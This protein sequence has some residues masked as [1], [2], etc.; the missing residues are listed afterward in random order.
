MRQKRCSLMRR[1]F[2]VELA[3]F[4]MVNSIFAQTPLPPEI[5]YDIV[6]VRAP[7]FGDDVITKMPEIKDPI[8]MEAGTDL[9]L[10]HVDGSEEVLV[11]GGNGAVADP[12]VSFDGKW[13]FYAKVHDLTNTNSQRKK[14]ARSGAD[15]FKINLDTRET[16]QLTF[17]EWTPNTGVGIWSTDHLTANPSGTNYLGYGIYNLGPAPLPNGKLIFTSSRNGFLPNKGFTFPNLQLFVM[18]QDGSNVEFV[19]HLNLGSALHPTVLMDGRVMFSSYEAQG[20]RDRRLW[21]LWSIYPDGRNWGPLM[22]AMKAPS[23]FH[24]QTQLSDGSIVV[25][26][27]YNQN[28]N[29]F[30]MLLKF[31]VSVPQSTAA[32]GSPNPNDSSS[33]S[34]QTGWFSNGKNQYRRYPF[35]PYGIESL[36]PFTHPNDNAAPFLN[37]TGSERTGKVTQPSGAP[38]NDLLLVWSPGPAN[39]LRRPVNR[40]SYDAGLYLLNGGIPVFDHHDLT[41]IKNDPNY[42]EQQPRAVLPYQAIYGI[43]EPQ[44]LPWLPNDGTVRQE[45]PKGTPYGL[46]GTSSFYKRDTKPG[47]GKAEFDGLDPFNTYQNGASSNWGSQGADAG[48]YDNSEIYAVRILGMEP[49]AHLSYGPNSLIGSESTS[50]WRNHASERLRILGEIPLR[51]YDSQGNPVLDPE[52]NPDTSFLAKIPAD[53]PFTFQTIDKDGRLLNAAQT[54]HQVRPG[55]VRY[56]CGGCHAHSQQP[57]DFNQTAAARSDYQ[58]LDLAKTTPLVSKD[59]EGNSTIKTVSKGAVDV[60]YYRDIK[61]ILERSCVQCHS[62]TGTA[63]ADLVLDDEELV[64]GFDNT[65][66]RLANDSSGEYGIPSLVTPYGWRQ[67]NASRYIRKFQSRRSLLIWKVFGQRLDGWTNADHPTASVPGDASTL[68]GGGDKS[69]IN[70]SDIDFTGTIM[71][72]PASGIPPLTEEEKMMFVRWVDLGAPIS[73]IGRDTVGWFA[74]ES[75]PT[76]TV[77]SPMAGAN[78]NRIDEIRIGMHDYYTGLAMTTFSVTANL[79]INGNSSG[80]ELAGLFQQSGDHIWTL[81]LDTPLESIQDGELTVSIKDQQGNITKVHRSFSIGD[82]TPPP[83]NHPPTILPVETQAVRAGKIL[84]FDVVVTDEDA[85]DIVTLEGRSLPSGATLIRKANH[86][87]TFSWTPSRETH[88]QFDV[89]FVAHDGIDES[90]PS[91]VNITV[92]EVPGNSVTIRLVARDQHHQEIPDASLHVWEKRQWVASGAEVE[93]EIGTTIQLR[94]KLGNYP[95]TWQSYTIESSITEIVVPFWTAALDAKDQAG[96]PVPGAYLQIYKGDGQITPGSRVT[97]PKGVEI[98]VR[99]VLGRYLGPWHFVTFTEGLERVVVPFWTA[100]LDAQDQ[101]GQLVPGG[102]PGHLSP[103]RTDHLREFG[104]DAQGGRGAGT[105]SHGAISRPVAPGRLH[106]GIGACSRALLDGHTG[107]PGSGRAAGTRGPPGHLSPRRTG[108]PRESGDDAQGDRGPRASKGR[109]RSDVLAKSDISRGSR[110]DYSR[111][112]IILLY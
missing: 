33:P 71:P 63:E 31:P 79:P 13:V 8:N 2:V 106:R 49:T 35:S 112:P 40:P 59:S 70:R 26:E 48:K 55:E 5:S 58:V 80:T 47:T 77:S 82:G 3:F 98:P 96:G 43:E 90:S 91:I 12:Y 6:Y 86:L 66:N 69:E 25:T 53:V 57:L 68:P 111:G 60:E 97:M 72:P 46:V 52:G 67:N 94:G 62:Q 56:D 100:I 110:G 65:Y 104:D 24:W 88:G 1:L 16:V 85:D 29:G 7:R 27:Y 81:R 83:T 54:W 51:K 107:C 30:G 50:N 89:T 75:R 95:G 78:P 41:L 17:Q 10:L 14:A 11:P 108:H 21:G 101:A 84:A 15:I 19:G 39:H 74:D 20:L 61:P 92:E 37:G 4:S 103:R 34:V 64:G 22:S 109:K 73:R 32:F 18:D 87:W 102:S 38:N 99:G 76:L 23:G 93:V 44:T 28:N 36:T 105:R 45:L 42:N 9:M